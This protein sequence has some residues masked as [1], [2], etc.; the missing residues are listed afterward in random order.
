MAQV[1]STLSEGKS[2]HRK[3]F[4]QLA[5]GEPFRVFGADNVFVKISDSAGV[6]VHATSTTSATLFETYNS[7]CDVEVDTNVRVHVQVTKLV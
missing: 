5:I 4:D 3:L 6:C 7:T 2:P 1:T